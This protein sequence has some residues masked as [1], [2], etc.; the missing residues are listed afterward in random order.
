MD[1]QIFTL[2]L[3][4]FC[5]GGIF[6]FAGIRHF[7]H[8]QPPLMIMKGRG[9]PCA[10]ATLIIGSLWEIALGLLVILGLWLIPVS[11]GLILFLVPATIIFHNFWGFQGIER[12]QHLHVVMTNIM[13]AGGLLV[14]AASA[15]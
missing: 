2:L 7:Q 13:V 11:L 12:V 15:T 9:V 1:F 6:I 10:T 3:G 14:L 8:F 5:I 4:R